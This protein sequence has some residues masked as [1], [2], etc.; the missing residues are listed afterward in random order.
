MPSCEFWY[1]DVLGLY[2]ARVFREAMAQLPWPER[3]AKVD[4]FVF[5]KDKCLCLGAGLLCAHALREAGAHDLAMDYGPHGKP[6]L[7]NH[8]HLHF[9]VSHSGT[10]VACAVSSDPVGIDVE[11]R[12]PYDEGVARLCFTHEELEWLGRQDDADQAFVRLWTRKES[13]LK[14]LGTGL[15]KPANSFSAMPGAYP[16]PNMCFCER[17]LANC[18]LCICTRGHAA[19][20]GSIPLVSLCNGSTMRGTSQCPT[21]EP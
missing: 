20:G 4:R 18:A 14:L 7:K 3:R 12:Q 1:C 5:Q 9:N 17:E 6:Y 8:P 15:S 21:E 11:E 19:T 10:M 13:Y 16:E 2:D